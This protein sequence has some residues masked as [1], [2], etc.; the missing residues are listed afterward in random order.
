MNIKNVTT[1]RVP[2]RY[3]SDPGRAMIKR[4]LYLILRRFHEGKSTTEIA[5]EFDTSR[6]SIQYL[7]RRYGHVDISPF[8]DL[9]TMLRDPKV[10]ER[11]RESARN[12]LEFVGE[13]EV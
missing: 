5:A 13:V 2:I 11:Y 3:P 8:D 9:I 4:N 1:E 12:V 10:P 6:Q 7:L